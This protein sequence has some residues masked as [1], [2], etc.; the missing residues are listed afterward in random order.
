ME[1]LWFVLRILGG[2]VDVYVSPTEGALA[3]DTNYILQV[4][5]ARVFHGR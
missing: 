5:D 3:K 4:E 2:S 1:P